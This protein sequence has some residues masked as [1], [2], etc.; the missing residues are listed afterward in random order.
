VIDLIKKLQE[1]DSDKEIMVDIPEYDSMG[2][3][4]EYRDIEIEEDE[5]HV[6][7][8]ELNGR[9]YRVDAHVYALRGLYSGPPAEGELEEST[10]D[11]IPEPR[12]TFLHSLYMQSIREML[13]NQTTQFLIRDGKA[14][15]MT[16]Q[17]FVEFKIHK[18][19]NDESSGD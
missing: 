18:E 13:E 12:N 19:E 16:D 5:V 15:Q 17:G 3:D 6:R 9:R 4:I 10:P 7:N 14:F 1:L 11:L 8:V 2:L